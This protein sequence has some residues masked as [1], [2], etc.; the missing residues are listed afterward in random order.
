MPA[1]TTQGQLEISDAQGRPVLQATVHNGQA[2]NLRTLAAGLYL[3][4]V[5]AGNEVGVVKF[6][7][8]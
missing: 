5:V 1:T 6:T 4:R 7:K 3:S 2:L 8:E